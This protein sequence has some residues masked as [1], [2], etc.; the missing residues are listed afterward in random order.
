MQ[1]AP[2]ID[3]LL[4]QFSHIDH[5]EPFKLQLGPTWMTSELTMPAVNVNMAIGQI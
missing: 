5:S 2:A 1:S 4:R 3:L